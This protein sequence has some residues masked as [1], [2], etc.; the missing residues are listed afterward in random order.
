MNEKKNPKL[1]PKD[2]IFRMYNILAELAE[3]TL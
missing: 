1:S 3:L 2:Y